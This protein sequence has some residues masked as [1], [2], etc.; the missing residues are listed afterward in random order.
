MSRLRLDVQKNL[1][2]GGRWDTGTDC[3]EECGCPVLGSVQGQA[4]GVF[5]QSDVVGGIDDF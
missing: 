4:G 3:S 1:L 5:E 2:Q